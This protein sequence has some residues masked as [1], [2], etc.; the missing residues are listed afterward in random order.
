MT[1]LGQKIEAIDFIPCT[2]FKP[3]LLEGQLCYS[4]DIRSLE[5]R[6]TK[7]GKSAG[8]VLLIDSGGQQKE[9]TQEEEATIE[10]TLDLESSGTKGNSPKIYLNTLS[11]FTDFRVGSYGMAALKKMTGTDSFLKQ[12]DSEKK[13]R[14]GTLED[15]QT[16]WYLDTVQKR[17]GCIPWSLS[18]PLG[19]KV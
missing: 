7:S 16:K 12:T 6:K 13:C 11:S 14:I 5:K 19:S 1:L 2:K 10:N 18:W 9:H 4:I 15:C 3:S 8:L 17:C